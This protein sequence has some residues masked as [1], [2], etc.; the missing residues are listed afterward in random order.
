MRC[1]WVIPDVLSADGRDPSDEGRQ[2]S[3]PA[4]ATGHMP[5][6]SGPR[7]RRRSVS[8]ATASQVAVLG[9]DGIDAEIASFASSAASSSRSRSRSP[10][11][12]SR[13]QSPSTASDSLGY[14]S[15]A[16]SAAT[17]DDDNDDDGEGGGEDGGVGSH[18]FV[19]IEADPLCPRVQM[20]PC[21]IVTVP[22]SL[23]VL[24]LKRRLRRALATSGSHPPYQPAARVRASLST[25]KIRLYRRVGGRTI[26]PLR[27]DAE[28][29]NCLAGG[30]PDKEVALQL[31]ATEERLCDDT[32]LL[33]YTILDAAGAPVRSGALAA[34]GLWTVSALQGHLAIISGISR[35]HLAISKAPPGTASRILSSQQL[36]GLVWDDP[37]I[38]HCTKLALAFADGDCIVMRDQMH[39]PPMPP[40]ARRT[41]VRVATDDDGAADVGAS[42]QPRA[43]RGP[44]VQIRGPRFAN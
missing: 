1:S 29:G 17:S 15:A 30:A 44:G 37:A 36:G 25:G 8:W 24:D 5:E 9:D 31:L 41:V 38:L 28:V 42:W 32:F 2:A 18:Q 39:P 16:S 26:L 6:E 33:G 35:R 22:E 10:R 3:P 19:R 20:Q 7:R 4:A 27:E 21:A 23:C 34:N 43:R 12:R 11:S 14:S 40:I 13:S